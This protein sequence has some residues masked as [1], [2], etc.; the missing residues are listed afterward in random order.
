LQMSCSII[1]KSWERLTA[2]IQDPKTRHYL[3]AK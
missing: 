1:V 3:V 2:H